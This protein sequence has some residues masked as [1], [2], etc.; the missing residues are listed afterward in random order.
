VFESG[1]IVQHGSYEELVREAGLYQKL[2]N[3]Q[4][5]YYV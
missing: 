4:A 1:N 2:W 5:Q 3:A